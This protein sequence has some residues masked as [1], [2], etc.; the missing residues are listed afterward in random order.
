MFGFRY[1]LKENFTFTP[2]ELKEMFLTSLTFAFIL[3]ALFKGFLRQKIILEETLLFFIL[4]LLFIVFSLWV[5]IALQ[6]AVAIRLGYKATYSYWSNGILLSLFLSFMTF[7]FVPFILPGSVNIEHLPKIRLGKF[8][9]GLNLKDL[10]RVCVAGPLAH[11][12]LIMIAGILFFATNATKEGYI[13]AF[14]AVNLFFVFYSILPIPKLDIPTKMDAGSD[15]LGLFFYSRTIYILVFSTIVLYILLIVIAS[16]F[17]FILAF[18][19]GTIT[20]IFYA[21]M[22][23]QKN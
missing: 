16:I 23:E 22:I 5:H 21:I 15:G 6:K 8:R 1:A 10:A 18:G 19:M 20:A 3:T 2:T 17:S 14:I 9:Y 11:V 4:I 13:Y 12:F 7:G